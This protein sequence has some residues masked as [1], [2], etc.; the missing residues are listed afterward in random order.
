[1]DFESKV[2]AASILNK[3]AHYMSNVTF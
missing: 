1:M 3:C 2:I